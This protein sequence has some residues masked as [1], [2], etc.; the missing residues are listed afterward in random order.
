[1]TKTLLQFLLGSETKT[2]ACKKNIF[3]ITGTKKFNVKVY[4]TRKSN[5]LNVIYSD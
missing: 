2:F 4:I 3:I 1:M 5:F